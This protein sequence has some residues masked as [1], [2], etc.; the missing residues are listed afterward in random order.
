MRLENGSEKPFFADPWEAS[1]SNIDVLT[2]HYSSSIPAS[3][4]LKV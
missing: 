4:K 1:S 2:L 3:C